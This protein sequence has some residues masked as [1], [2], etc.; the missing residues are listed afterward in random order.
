ME[1]TTPRPNIFAR[2]SFTIAM[3]VGSI[4]PFMNYVLGR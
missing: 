1:K 2:Y 4:G 3:V